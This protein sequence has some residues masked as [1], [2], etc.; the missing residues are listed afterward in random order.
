M[1]SSLAC[2]Q[3]SRGFGAMKATLSSS[4]VEMRPSS[5]SNDE[6][7][8]SGHDRSITKASQNQGTLGLA[9]SYSP[10]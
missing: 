1:S 4:W 6:S 7:V 10:V 8:A 2:G 9:G 3:V 5:I